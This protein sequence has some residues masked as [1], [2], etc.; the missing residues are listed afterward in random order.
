M[1][2]KKAGARL[3]KSLSAV[4]RKPNN[5]ATDPTLKA[6]PN[7]VIKTAAAGNAANIAFLKR[8]FFL[9]YMLCLSKKKA[10]K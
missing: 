6:E 8:N 4:S 3:N 1:M 2:K 5:S 7:K 10:F 9:K